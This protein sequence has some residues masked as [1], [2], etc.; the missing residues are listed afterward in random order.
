MDIRN[1][2]LSLSS[3]SPAK[4]IKFKLGQ[5]NFLEFDTIWDSR[6]KDWISELF[7]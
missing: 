5:N 1:L 4:S 2:Y 7:L 6:M 3:I